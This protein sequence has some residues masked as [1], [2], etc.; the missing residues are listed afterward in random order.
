MKNTSEIEVLNVRLPSEIVKW[1][2]L[3]VEKG[4]YKS[5]S[6]AIRDFCRDFVK[7]S[8]SGNHE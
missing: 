7:K 6:E 4:V 3:M 2:D 5:R 1:L 8:R